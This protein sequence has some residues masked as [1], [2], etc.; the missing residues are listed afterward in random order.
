[1]ARA[2]DIIQN[3]KSG[4]I[5]GLMI[6]PRIRFALAGSAVA[7]LLAVF[8]LLPTDESRQF[9]SDSETMPGTFVLFPRDGAIITD[10]DSHFHWISL[11]STLVYRFSLLETTGRV[12]WITDT[13]DT[14]VA[15][16]QSVV[17]QPGK[18]YLWRVETSL[19]DKTLERSALHAFTYSP[20]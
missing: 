5:R 1:M 13:P 2:V 19:A 9:R 11:G 17:L 16:P 4:W 3:H 15:I 6:Q 7:V 18:V 10:H 20:Q 8:F 12:I 14:A